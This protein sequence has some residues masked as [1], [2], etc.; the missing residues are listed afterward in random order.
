MRKI[1][2]TAPAEYSE[3]KNRIFILCLFTGLCGF[4]IMG[5]VNDSIVT[6]NPF[7]WFNFGIAF[8]WTVSR[9]KE[10]KAE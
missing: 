3:D 4:M 7:F 8:Y 5:L 6:V 9:D 1:L 10:V 2:R